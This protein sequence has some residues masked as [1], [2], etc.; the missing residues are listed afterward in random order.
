MYTLNSLESKLNKGEIFWD[1]GKGYFVKKVLV[2]KIIP[3]HP[4]IFSFFL[5][6]RGEYFSWQKRGIEGKFPLTYFPFSS[7]LYHPRRSGLRLS[8][9]FL[10]VSLNFFYFQISHSIGTKIFIFS[11]EKHVYWN[12]TLFKAFFCLLSLNYKFTDLDGKNV[13]NLGCQHRK[14]LDMGGLGVKEYEREKKNWIVKR[15]ENG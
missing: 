3:L 13:D 5:E 1:V 14:G 6:G 12:Q 8:N 15:G 10:T 9:L 7:P 2:E 11:K 4:F